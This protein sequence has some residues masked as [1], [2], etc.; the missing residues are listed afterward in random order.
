MPLKPDLEKRVSGVG[1]RTAGV[2]TPLY[3]CITK[4]FGGGKNAS[5]P[6]LDVEKGFLM[7][8][9]N[10]KGGFTTLWVCFGG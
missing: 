2:D 3:V 5:K 7:S 10:G 9:S 8:G 1:V 4:V 6:N